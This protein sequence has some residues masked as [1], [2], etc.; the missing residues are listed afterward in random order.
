MRKFIFAGTLILL[1]GLFCISATTP[2]FIQNKI[3][4]SKSMSSLQ[5]QAEPFLKQGWKV[6]IIE[7]QSVSTAIQNAHNYPNSYR[8]IMG[9]VIM[10]LEK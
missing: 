10:V 7:S 5:A 3:L 8:D 1:M 9:D 2:L 4:V 6:K